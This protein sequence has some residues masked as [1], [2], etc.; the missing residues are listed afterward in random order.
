[1]VF[2]TIIAPSL[3]IVICPPIV[4]L[5]WFTHTQLDGSVMA[6]A[7]LMASKGVASTIRHI[8][9]PIIFGSPTAWAIVAI[10][11]SLE[12]VFMRLL[13][14]RRSQG[15]TSPAGD[16]PVYKA[17]GV[18]SF[19]LTIA[20]FALC[21]FA[22]GL[23]PPTI[24]Y[25]HFG[26]ILGALNIFALLFCVCLCLKGLYA[27]SSADHGSGSNPIFDYYWGTELYPRILGSDVKM[28]VNCRFAMM[29]WP[30]IVLS[31]A[32][33]Q[34]E[35]YGVISDS[36]MVAVALQMFY[37]AKFFWWE[38]GYLRSLD[39]MHDRAGFYL[40]WGC[41]VWLPSIYTSSTLYL[42]GHPNHLG[43]PLVGAIL[44]AG[45]SAILVNYLADAQRQNV[46]AAQG[47][48]KVWGKAPVLVHARYTMSGGE[49]KTNI[50]LASGWWG[51]A[52]H[53]HYVP[54]IA[55][56]FCWTV[57]A[58]FD[59]ALPYLYPTY[60]VILLVDRALRDEKRCA[61]KYGADW[62]VYCGIVPYMII[63]RI[64]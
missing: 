28:F 32:A 41:M 33:K 50:L 30:L 43:A 25:D 16:V 26:E 21:S 44:V 36:M 63:P 1:M 14:G 31:F 5:I 27:P 52:R 4:G 38:T 29:G 59:N 39:I 49:A 6:L 40:C 51:I 58:L 22:L 11:A 23:F 35:L 56:A 62:K 19:A 9:Q 20:L 64:M 8:W 37:V 46:R 13:P 24:I 34:H 12:L 57:P 42:V 18:A 45:C 2:R 53:F 60:L 15:P 47:R 17:N 55:G 10:F 7:Q 3:L 61:A 54:E 48:I